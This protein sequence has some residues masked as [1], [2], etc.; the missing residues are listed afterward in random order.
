MTIVLIDRNGWMKRIPWGSHLSG[1]MILPT[2]APPGSPRMY[3]E[4]TFRYVGGR[5]SGNIVYREYP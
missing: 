5:S 4:R 3:V 1:V 2:L